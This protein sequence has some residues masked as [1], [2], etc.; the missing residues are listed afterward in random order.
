MDHEQAFVHSFIVK[1]KQS[2]YLEKLASPKHRR[3]FLSRLHHNLDY[4]P[5]FAVQVPPSE[6]SAA[7]V[8]AK[9]RELGAPE[10]CHA[11]A[12]GTDLDGRQLPLR[13]A[14]ANVLGMGNGVVLSC[15]PGKLAYYESEDANGRYILSRSSAA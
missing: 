12:A 11:I 3:E 13:E 10:H 14:L 15:I 7:L 4:D 8:Y 2:R 6:Q 5:K 1:S 9:L